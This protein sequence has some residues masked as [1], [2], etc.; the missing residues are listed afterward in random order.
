MKGRVKVLKVFYLKIK[1]TV[2]NIA[3][4]YANFDVDNFDWLSNLYTV[5]FVFRKTRIGCNWHVHESWS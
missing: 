4:T 1:Q 2:D 3:L 5:S